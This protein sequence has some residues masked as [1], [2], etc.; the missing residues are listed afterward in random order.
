MKNLISFFDRSKGKWISQRTT[1]ELSTKNMSS[2]QSQM[3]VSSDKSLSGSVIVASLNW[4]EIAR[5][6]NHNSYSS[7]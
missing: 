2:V 5:Q 4:G 7:E 1:Y 6:V 3:Q